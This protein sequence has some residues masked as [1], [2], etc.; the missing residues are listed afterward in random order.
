MAKEEIMHWPFIGWVLKHSGIFGGKR[1]L[2][3]IHI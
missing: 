2:S 3:L 1:G